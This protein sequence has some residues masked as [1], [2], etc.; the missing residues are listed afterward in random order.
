MSGIA[1]TKAP[2]LFDRQ[3]VE[4]LIA[5]DG[6]WRFVRFGVIGAIT[7]LLQFAALELFKSLGIGSIPAYALS[8]IPAVQVNFIAN[9]VLVWDDRHIKVVRSRAMFDRWLTFQ[10]CIA[11]SLVINFAVFVVAQF[12]VPDIVAMLMGI[13]ASTL[14]KFLS[15]DRLAFRA[16]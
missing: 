13:G 16:V 15:L 12:F 6:T 4:A 8:L 10:G 9:E 2:S 3:R 7:F 11:F 5:K 14:V 1:D